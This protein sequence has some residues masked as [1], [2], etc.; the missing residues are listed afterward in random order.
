MVLVFVK[1]HVA[2]HPF[3]DPAKSLDIVSV[4]VFVPVV[5]YETDVDA[6]VDVDGDE[7]D[8]KDHE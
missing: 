4:I 7:P 5:L 1:L 6:D 8:P 3:A 2:L